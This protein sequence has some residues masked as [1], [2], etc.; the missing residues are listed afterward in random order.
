ME[1]MSAQARRYGKLLLLCICPAIFLKIRQRLWIWEKL[2]IKDIKSPV[3]LPLLKRL[4]AWRHGCSSKFMLRFNLNNNNKDRYLPDMTYKAAHPINGMFSTLI[5]NKLNLY[6]TPRDYREH[7]PAY[8]L[9]IYR[10]EIISLDGRSRGMDREGPEIILD[11]CREKGKLAMKRLVGS[12]GAGFYMIS[13]DV[14]GFQWNGKPISEQEL[15]TKCLSLEN[16]LLTEYVQQ[17]QYARL[18]YPNT[19]NTLRIMTPR[20]HDV[21]ESFII[22]VLQRIGTSRSTTHADHVALGGMACDVN[23]QS[24]EINRTGCFLFSKHPATYLV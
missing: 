17:H 22:R 24:G 8:Y 18:F 4:W 9:L 3:K 7:L 20:D 21:H 23:I 11:L 5:D 12:F 2:I 15:K 6:F 14:G 19:T 16:Y 10:N 1:F 13:F